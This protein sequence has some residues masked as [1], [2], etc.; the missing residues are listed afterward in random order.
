MENKRRYK[1]FTRES[2]IG[3]KDDNN[4]SRYDGKSISSA[5]ASS[6]PS[7]RHFRGA[8]TLSGQVISEDMT[9]ATIF[10]DKIREV[11]KPLLDTEDVVYTKRL[12]T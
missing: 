1:Y 11:R 8:W 4:Y 6:V 7:D 3:D 12:E 10:K 9:I 2:C 5:D